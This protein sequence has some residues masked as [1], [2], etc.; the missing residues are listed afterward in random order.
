MTEF[1]PRTATGVRSDHSTDCATT[2]TTG[3]SILNKIKVEDQLALRKAILI[4]FK[5]DH[6]WANIFTNI[7]F[8]NVLKRRKMRKNRPD[9]YVL[10]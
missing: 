7:C 9:F 10:K 3:Q 2:P 8:G 5:I 6:P 4:A 1:K